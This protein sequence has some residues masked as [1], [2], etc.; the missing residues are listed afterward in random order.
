MKE[1]L[2][3]ADIKKMKVDENLIECTEG[4]VR[5]YKFLCFH[6]R[7]EKYVILLNCYEQPV[8]FYY[9]D[10][11]KKF[12]TD[13]T[14]IDILKYKKEY[15]RNKLEKIERELYKFKNKEKSE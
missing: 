2:D 14:D 4:E 6:P 13:Y 10:I 9:Q 3:I 11:I 12:F 7:N 5:Y 8:R 15:L 1:F